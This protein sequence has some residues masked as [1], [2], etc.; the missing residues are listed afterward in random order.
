MNR[1]LQGKRNGVNFQGPKG[2]YQSDG[3]NLYLD[4]GG[5]YMTVYICQILVNVTVGD[6]TSINPTKKRMK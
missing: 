6:Y 5:D 2:I 3:Y 1:K 4:Y